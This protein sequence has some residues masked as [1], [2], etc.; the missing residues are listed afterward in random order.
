MIRTSTGRR[1][2]AGVAAAPLL[3]AVL[4]GCGSDGDGTDASVPAAQSQP[5]GGGA[6]PAPGGT[7]P[8]A[9]GRSFPGANG[10]V[11]ALDGSTAQVRNA[12]TGQVAV[13]WQDDTVFTATVDGSVDD[14]EVGDCVVARGADQESAEPAESVQ[15]TEPVDGS[16]AA[17]GGFG[18]R[19]GPGRGMPGPGSGS[20][21]PERP[22]GA[23]S[24]MPGMGGERPGL[25]A[26]VT[27]EV[28]AVDAGS[29]T[30]DAVS[31]AAPPTEGEQETAPTTETRTVAVDDAT[32][33]TTTADADADAVAVGVCVQATGE[34]D[35]VGAVTA[36]T[37]AV[38]DPI[39]GTCGIGGFGMRTPPAGSTT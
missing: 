39:D 14:I 32:A 36:E 25:G 10:E 16:C 4:T 34:T 9:G 38:S 17:A 12:S 15:V 23:P 22:E 21:A 20:G 31:F 18:G 2:L 13:S 29:L 37:I 11:V 8:G 28:T 35:D 27:G 26:I 30:I 24:G 3:V 6:A 19:M 33:V 5:Q 1:R 7:G